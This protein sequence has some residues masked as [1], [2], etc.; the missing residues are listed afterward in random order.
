[1]LKNKTVLLVTHGLQFLRH[2]DRVDRN[3][4]GRY[5][6]K[7]HYKDHNKDHY[8]D[9][10]KDHNKDHYKDHFK[11]DAITLIFFQTRSSS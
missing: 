2:C 3:L 7:D 9:Y 10:Y 8:T 4:Q 1:M 11:D 6:N 5:H